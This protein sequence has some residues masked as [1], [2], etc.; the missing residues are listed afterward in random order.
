MEVVHG[1]GR[2]Q[3]AV[4]SSFHLVFGKVKKRQERRSKP[5]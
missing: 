3:D 2:G 4:D 5:N 1:I